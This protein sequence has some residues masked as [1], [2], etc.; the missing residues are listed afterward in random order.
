MEP[1]DDFLCLLLNF[2]ELVYLMDLF[3][4]LH[5]VSLL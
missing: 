3:C 1:G 5:C 2:H 4:S